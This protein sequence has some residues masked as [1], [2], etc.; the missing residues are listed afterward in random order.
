MRIYMGI[1]NAKQL[2]FEPEFIRHLGAFV[3]SLLTAVIVSYVGIIGFI[4]LVVLHI[5]RFLVGS[6]HLFSMP[7]AIL[8]GTSIALSADSIVKLISI[9]VDAVA[10]LP[11]GVVTSIIGALFLVYL[12][13]KRLRE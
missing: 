7:T 13:I 2:G 1:P 11:L 4:E 5:A 8:V 9:Y 3:V 10:E 6:N 12:I